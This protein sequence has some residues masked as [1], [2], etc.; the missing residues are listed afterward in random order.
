[1]G[2][3]NW[4]LEKALNKIEWVSR[5]GKVLKAEHRSEKKSI[6]LTVLLHG[7]T[8]PIDFEI[9][10]HIE[11]EFFIIEKILIEKTW[12]ND[13]AAFY[14]E[15]NKSFKIS[16]HSKTLGAIVKILF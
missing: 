14:F 11:N 6:C 2:F 5:F 1:M 16:L 7:E 10:Y 13:V 15:K 8:Q 12:L 3:I 4:A 9:F